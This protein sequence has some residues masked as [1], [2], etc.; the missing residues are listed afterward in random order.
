MESIKTKIQRLITDREERCKEKKNLLV[1]IRMYDF[2]SEKN[3]EIQKGL[4]KRDKQIESIKIRI[5]NSPIDKTWRK[6]VSKIKICRFPSEC[7]IS[8]VRKI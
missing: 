8:I 7:M 5:E 4:L 3:L 1:S 2:E 6:D